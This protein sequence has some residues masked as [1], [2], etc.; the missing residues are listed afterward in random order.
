MIYSYWC[1]WL[2]HHIHL[3]LI[4]YSFFCLFLLDG[5]VQYPG[6]E[7]LCPCCKAGQKWTPVDGSSTLL[8][9]D[10]SVG[11]CQDDVDFKK[12]HAVSN[13]NNNNITNT[14]YRNTVLVSRVE[15]IDNIQDYY[16]LVNGL[17]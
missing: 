13:N 4:L 5:D 9:C 10:E 14:Q 1:L 3:E 12:T 15:L 11:Q 2:R 7:T 17:Q 8:R 16:Y 6:S